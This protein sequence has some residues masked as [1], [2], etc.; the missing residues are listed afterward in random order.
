MAVIGVSDHGR[1]RQETHVEDNGVQEGRQVERR[2]AVCPVLVLPEE[3]RLFG[4]VPSIYILSVS[5]SIE[6]PPIGHF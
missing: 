1:L 3:E 2:K 4:I 5:T 6:A